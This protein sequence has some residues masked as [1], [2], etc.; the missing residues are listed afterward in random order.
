MP[1]LACI[2]SSAPNLPIFALFKLLTCLCWVMLCYKHEF[3]PLMCCYLKKKKKIININFDYCLISKKQLSTL[4]A[5]CWTQ[6]I[7]I[8]L[9]KDHDTVYLFIFSSWQVLGY[10]HHCDHCGCPISWWSSNVGFLLC[11]GLSTSCLQ[12]DSYLTRLGRERGSWC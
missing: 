8:F 6:S 12:S 10:S 5:P 1:W 4:I 2:F 9:N 7:G 3:C 11:W